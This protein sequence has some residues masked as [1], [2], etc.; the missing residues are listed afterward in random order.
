LLNFVIEGDMWQ[1]YLRK[2]PNKLAPKTVARSDGRAM[3]QQ[4]SRRLAPP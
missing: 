3:W 4:W 2:L 1:K